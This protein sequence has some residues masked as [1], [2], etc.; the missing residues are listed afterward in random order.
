[1]AGI[2]VHIPFCKSRCI[3]CG[4]FSTTQL[5]QRDDYVNCVCKEL[6]D[7]RDYLNGE[8]IDTIYFGGG[9]PSL[10][11]VNHLK[12]IF[13]TIYNYYNVRAC[14]EITLEGNPDDLT[15]DFLKSIQTLGFNRLSMGV[16]SF[17]DSRLEFIQ[18]RHS[19]RQALEALSNAVQAG[20]GNISID[21]MFGF[22]DQTLDEWS[23][24]VDTALSLPVQHISAYSLMYEEG[25]LMSRMLENGEIEEID[26]SLSL[27]MYKCLVMKLREK[28]FEHYEISNFCLP[29]YHS[30][31][32]SSYWHGIPYLGV[33]A[34]AHSYDAISRQYN[35]E[36]L[37]AYLSGAAPQTEVLSSD[38]RYNEFVFT[39]L[40]TS[41][42]LSL[43]ELETV[44]G[45][46][47]SS[48][49]LS[50]AQEHITAGRLKL[51][52]VEGENKKLVLTSS[53]IF[54]SND[55]ISD[56]MMVD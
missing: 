52:P 36:S 19:S 23:R 30:R 39:G 50:N 41:Q 12:R 18:R 56:L 47:Y 28:G 27:E 5:S 37:A 15:P 6:A 11:D 53:G 51:Y 31:H 10:L 33:G 40:R 16:Q 14:A 32:N 35:V 48:Y 9:T 4:F 8:P 20:F 38:E 2:Y 54:V 49:C 29:G 25:T 21:L 46:E 44:F 7:R 1:M 34:G 42:G 45:H 22:P 43:T 26:E 3:Y 24:D 13:D 17:V 55:I